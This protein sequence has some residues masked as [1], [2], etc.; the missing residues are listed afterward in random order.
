M[1]R[2]YYFLSQ[3]GYLFDYLKIDNYVPCFFLKFIYLFIAHYYGLQ[4]Y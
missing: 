3:L 4:G 2:Y 1:Q